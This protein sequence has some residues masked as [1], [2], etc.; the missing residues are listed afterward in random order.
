M[1]AI[2]KS[3]HSFGSG[4][5][6]LKVC[7]RPEAVAYPV[8]GILYYA[9]ETL[10]FLEDP[11]MSKKL[12]LSDM[13]ALAQVIG[14]IGVIISL[15]FVLV[16][17]NKNTVQASAATTQGFFTAYREIELMV[18]ADPSWS[19]IVLQGRKQEA[20]LTEVEQFRYDQ[21]VEAIIDLWDQLYLRYQDELTDAVTLRLWEE[22]FQKW[23]KR[24][25]SHSTW[26]RIKWNY[27]YGM[28]K[29]IEAAIGYGQI[30]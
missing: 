21:Y 16:E 7:F 29:K 11:A 17:I 20:D 4:Q 1:A 18:A 12:S 8:T 2:P 27:D 3:G 26:E 10:Y 15:I 6:L 13:A 25:I 5:P 28:D 14:T 19:E 23:A 22:W 9:E 24:N 30:D